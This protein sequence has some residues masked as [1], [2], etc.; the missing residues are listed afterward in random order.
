MPRTKSG[1]IP[2]PAV[3]VC[4]G[5]DA[6][7]P[8]IEL[9]ETSLPDVNLIIISFG[10]SCSTTALIILGLVTP[11]LLAFAF[12]FDCVLT[13]TKLVIGYP[14][15]ESTKAPFTSSGNMDEYSILMLSSG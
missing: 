6:V 4:D 7:P 8:L 5:N 11:T 12:S 9:L 3:P 10:A 14:V 15:E 1:V 13:V 2:Y